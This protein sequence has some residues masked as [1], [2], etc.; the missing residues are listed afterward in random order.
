MSRYAAIVKHQFRDLQDCRV[1]IVEVPK[2]IEDIGPFEVQKFIQNQLLGYFTV[3][4][5][6]DRISF[7]EFKTVPNKGDSL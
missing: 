7:Q 2:E 4:C 6:T 1:E 3:I 5:V